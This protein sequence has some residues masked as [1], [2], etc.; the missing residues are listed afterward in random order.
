VH[1]V[2]GGVAMLAARQPAAKGGLLGLTVPRACDLIARFAVMKHLRV[3][4]GA[5]LVLVELRGRQH[6]DHLD[7]V[8]IRAICRRWIRPVER[9]PAG[10][11]LRLQQLAESSTSTRPRHGGTSHD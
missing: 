1:S 2:P 6:I 4:S 9:L 10:R 7:P 11:M 8:P 5:G 3:L